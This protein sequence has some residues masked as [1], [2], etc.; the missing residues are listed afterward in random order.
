MG[1]RDLIDQLKAARHRRGWSQERVGA[2]MGISKN[3]VCR[4][5]SEVN[6]TPRLDTVFRYAAA[7][8]VSIHIH[9]PKDTP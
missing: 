3:A 7:L 4:L 2:R 9:D 5:E 6:R 1:H 8:G